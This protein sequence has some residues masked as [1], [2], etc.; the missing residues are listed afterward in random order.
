MSPSLAAGWK[1]I[2][3]LLYISHVLF[4]ILRPVRTL[5]VR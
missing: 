4:F 3:C 1:G 2:L 5:L